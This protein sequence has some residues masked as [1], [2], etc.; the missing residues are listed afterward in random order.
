MIPSLHLHI[1]NRMLV[2]FSRTERTKLML[3]SA[4]AQ[5]WMINAHIAHG[6]LRTWSW[7]K[8][9]FVQCK[10][11][12][13]S[14]GMLYTLSTFRARSSLRGYR[15]MKIFFGGMPINLMSCSDTILLMWLN[16]VSTNDANATEIGISF[17]WFHFLRYTDSIRNLPVAT[18]ILSNTTWPGYWVDIKLDRR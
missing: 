3:S 16:T 10:H 7:W 5:F 14:L 13:H 12:C 11:Q 6:T 1:I 4:M 8:S 15:T 18:V 17:K 2:P 9:Q